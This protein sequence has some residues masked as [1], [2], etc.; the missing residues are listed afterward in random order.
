VTD[1]VIAAGP[2]DETGEAEHALAE[3]AF[4]FWIYLMSDAMRS[5][6]WM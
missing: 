2:H 1:A 5:G 4:G 3:T 6:S